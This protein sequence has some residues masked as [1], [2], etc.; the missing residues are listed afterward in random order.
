MI[1]TSEQDDQDA[2]YERAVLAARADGR[3]QEVVRE[4]FL[5]TDPRDAL[6]AFRTSEHY[7]RARRL[8][9]RMGVS[10][11]ARVVDFGGGRGILT[12]ALA[13]EG[14]EVTLCEPN[15]SPV[16]GT[17]AAAEVAERTGAAFAVHAGPV[18]DLADAGFDAV[19]CRAVLHHVSPLVP[20]L[21]DVHSA[22]R[23]GGALVATDEPTVRR[24]ADLAHL[25]EHHPFVAFGVDE[26]A[27]RV[28]DYATALGRAGFVGVR[29][30]FPVSAGDYRRHLRPGDALA[31]LRYAAWRAYVA[32]RHPPGLVRSFTA[33]RS[34]T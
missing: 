14:Y 6:Q 11:P 31:P 21:R 19:I 8:L 12:A 16:C 7:S 17:G 20:V 9:H 23:P 13:L 29:A 2:A 5:H 15:P 28:R 30:H 33:R 3:L 26:Q 34:A 18:E 32:A 25:R 24:A 22:L 27:L 4:A 1:D 10:P